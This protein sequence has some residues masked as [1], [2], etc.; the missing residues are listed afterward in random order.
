MTLKLDWNSIYQ[1]ENLGNS[2]DKVWQAFGIPRQS[3]IQEVG[4]L[5]LLELPGS[6]YEGLYS[7]HSNQNPSKQSSIHFPFSLIFYEVKVHWSGFAMEF[8]DRCNFT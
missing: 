4:M 2:G 1:A 8:Y 7:I 3:K 6:K 5:P